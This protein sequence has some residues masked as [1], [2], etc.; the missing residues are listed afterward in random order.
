MQMKG[1]HM[2]RIRSAIAIATVGSFVLAALVLPGIASAKPPAGTQK[3]KVFGGTPTVG[4]LFDSATSGKHFCT[5]SV[6][7]S[8]GGDVL[9]TAAHCIDGSAKGL[10]FAPGFH[11]GTAPYGRWTVTGAYFDPAWLSGQNP[12]RDFA[13]LTVAPR[14][15]AGVKTEIQ[16]VTGANV[17]ST[18]PSSGE[19][20]TVPA[21]PD[22]QAKVPI[23][24][25]AK[26]YYEGIY[27]AFNCNPYI[28]GTS[29]SPWLAATSEGVMVVG[30]IAGLHQGGCFT[31]TSYSPP[32]GSAARATYNRAVAGAKPDI[33]PEAG[34]DGCSTGL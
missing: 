15:L 27:P 17:L 9:M 4:A 23:T 6:V 11:D 22:G 31:Y 16:T 8:P 3:S 19:T 26:A 28:G 30:L 14:M 32:L 25:T 29:G 24:C 18:K 21:Y 2:R 5:A 13:F 34:S 1:Q 20:V 33:G 10:S 7:S 12:T